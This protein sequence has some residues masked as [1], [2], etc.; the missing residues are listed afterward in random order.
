MNQE[1]LAQLKQ[2]TPAEQQQLWQQLQQ[3]ALTPGLATELCEFPY[4]CALRAL[5]EQ[6]KPYL[7]QNLWT[8]ELPATCPQSLLLGYLLKTKLR[9]SQQLPFI[10]DFIDTKVFAVSNTIY[11][12]GNIEDW[13]LLIHTYLTNLHDRSSDDKPGSQTALYQLSMLTWVNQL[14]TCGTR[15]QDLLNLSQLWLIGMLRFHNLDTPA[16]R[17]R[18]LTLT[19][20]IQD[21]ELLHDFDQSVTALWR[22]RCSQSIGPLTI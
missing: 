2:L 16:N 7:G 18:W 19:P 3:P 17:E 22:D 1:L 10:R 5:G 8:V 13:R 20:L 15:T 9:P 14:L 12:H 6:L 21:Q 11:N 4:N